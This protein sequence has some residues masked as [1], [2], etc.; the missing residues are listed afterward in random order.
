MY[1][2]KDINDDSGACQRHKDFRKLLQT[3]FQMSNNDNFLTITK[4]DPTLYNIQSV[5]HGKCWNNEFW[6]FGQTEHSL[7]IT[8]T[9]VPFSAEGEQRIGIKLELDGELVYIAS[10]WYLSWIPI[11]K[12]IYLPW[13]EICNDDIDC[14]I[15]FFE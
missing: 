15:C 10:N 1:T 13:L 12:K 14:K 3:K 11:K 6:T 4:S 8:V 2:T 7:D 5:S 9:F